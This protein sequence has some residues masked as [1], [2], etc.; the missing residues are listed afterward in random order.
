MFRSRLG[1]SAVVH[2]RC[3]GFVI[4]RQAA[5]EWASRI[6][7]KTYTERQLWAI[8]SA[9]QPKA[10][11]FNAGFELFGETWEEMAFMVITRSE[12]LIGYKMGSSIPPFS[13]GERE[14]MA[15]PLLE[16]EGQ[17]IMLD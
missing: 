5:A 12:K 13:E 6:T 1:V 17:L 9:I 8:E 2:Y 4:S 7:G 10:R 16:G 3:G 14:V 11:V 15:K